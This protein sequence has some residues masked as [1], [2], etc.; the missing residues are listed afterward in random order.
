MRPLPETVSITEVGLRDGLQIEPRILATDEKVRLAKA[1][2]AAGHTAPKYHATS[3][4]PV[5]EREA[6]HRAVALAE[7]VDQPIHVFHVSCAEAAEEIAQAGG[8]KV[9]GKTYNFECL[10]YDNKYN[11]A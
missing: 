8:V 9:A 1:L 6:T 10:A 4:P 11:A 3:R 2:I 5:V 7:L